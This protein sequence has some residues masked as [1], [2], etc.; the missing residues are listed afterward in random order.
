MKEKNLYVISTKN[1]NNGFD[2]ITERGEL[3]DDLKEAKKFKDINNAITE[4]MELDEPDRFKVMKLT[5]KYWLS[6][7]N[8]K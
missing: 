3:S 7:L 5:V 1:Y 2:F 8:D 4:E 6:D